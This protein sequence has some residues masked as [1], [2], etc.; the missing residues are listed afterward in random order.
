[1]EDRMGGRS[2]CRKS[3]FPKGPLL[4]PAGKVLTVYLHLIY[5]YN[6]GVMLSLL[7]VYFITLQKYV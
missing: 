3:S 5:V 4:R 2:I 1:M 6:F 7:C